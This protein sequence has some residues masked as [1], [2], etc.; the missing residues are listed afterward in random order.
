MLLV[1]CEET[2]GG[3]SVGAESIAMS[4]ARSDVSAKPYRRFAA[5]GSLKRTVTACPTMI[6]PS[7]VNVALGTGIVTVSWNVVV[8]FSPSGLVAVMVTVVTPAAVGM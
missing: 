7:L 4:A 8:A 6:G 1:G 2:R 5:L 3:R